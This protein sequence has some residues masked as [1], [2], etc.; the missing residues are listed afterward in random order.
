[1]EFQRLLLDADRGFIGENNDEGQP[2]PSEMVELAKLCMAR[3]FCENQISIHRMQVA[4]HVGHG[5]TRAPIP[6]IVYSIP[7]IIDSFKLFPVY[8]HSSVGGSRLETARVEVVGWMRMQP[9]R[10]TMEKAIH[11][12]FP[13]VILRDKP[14]II[15]KMDRFF[16]PAIE[17]YKEQYQARL[18]DS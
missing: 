1:M 8:H 9:L 12:T 11:K 18:V 15:K 13:V 10:T 3:A 17:Q 7:E 14:F 4:E 5:H 6:I 16:A 2:Y